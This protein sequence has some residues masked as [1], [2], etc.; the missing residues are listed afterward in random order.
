MQ[1]L[2]NWINLENVKILSWKNLINLIK[3]KIKIDGC[4]NN[5]NFLF[6]DFLYIKIWII[7]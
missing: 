3:L 6:H 1:L 5:L 2:I 4:R 7:F